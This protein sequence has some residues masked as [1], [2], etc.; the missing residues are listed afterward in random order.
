MGKPKM[1]G[2]NKPYTPNAK[3]DRKRSKPFGAKSGIMGMSNLPLA[4]R[5]KMQKEADIAGNRER[6]ARVMMYCHCCA[7]HDVEGIG[8]KRLVKFA[9]RCMEI[10]KDFYED[11]Y[12]GMD[13]AK[14]RL[15]QM[16]ID[17]SGELYT[18][19][20][21]SL[22]KRDWEVGTNALQASQIAGLCAIIAMNDVFGIGKERQDR[23]SARV[24]ELT[25]RYAKEGVRFLLEEL[26]QIGFEIRDG[27]PVCYMDDDG[28]A[29]L[30][31]KARKEGW[32][33]K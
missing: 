12:L 10:V 33:G 15:A 25:E 8:Y 31:S 23:I 17:I 3:A 32:G 4:Q 9:N 26:E 7:L 28:T 11:I 22:S 1:Y 13:H 19:D 16:G 30:P 18:L 27:A 24:S 5:L 21:E 2:M 29:V 14:R 20:G 6:A